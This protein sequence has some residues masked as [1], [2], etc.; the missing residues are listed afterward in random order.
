MLSLIHIS[1]PTRQAAL[2][3]LRYKYSTEIAELDKGYLD[4]KKSMLYF[5]LSLI[6]I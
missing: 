3:V 1:E 2:H 6:H 4:L 5:D